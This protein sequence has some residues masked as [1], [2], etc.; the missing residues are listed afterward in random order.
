MTNLP[1]F[2]RFVFP[3]FCSF[4]LLLFPLA[5]LAQEAP[6]SVSFTP[7]DGWEEGDEIEM[8]I[9]YG[10]EEVPLENVTDVQF[11]IEMPEGTSVENTSELVIHG[12]NSWFTFDNGWTGSAEIAND[13]YSIIVSLSRTNGRPASGHGEVARV[14]G[15]IVEVAEIIWKGEVSGEVSVSYQ[16]ASSQRHM[17]FDS[18][19]KR[20]STTD[21]PKGAIIQLMDA[22]GRTILSGPVDQPLD[23][24]ALPAQYYVAVVSN[25]NQYLE[26]I[27]LTILP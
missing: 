27:T 26:H 12:E 11:E 6:V 23:L 5:L 19:S 16:L 8:I 25:E 21:L 10:S 1:R 4:L 17:A 18:V 20:I 14:K 24:S 9:H 15:L 3:A 2:N 7:P 13:G 22:M